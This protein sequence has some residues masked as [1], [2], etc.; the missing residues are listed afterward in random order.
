MGASAG[1][2]TTPMTCQ[3]FA[4]ALPAYRADELAPPLR[5]RAEQHLAGC[6]KCASYLRGYERTI[7]LAREASA[8][9][10]GQAELPEDLVRRIMKARR[11]S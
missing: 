1:M 7:E 3:E 10:S 8:D 11:R 6:A 5:I 9:R 2:T 4:D